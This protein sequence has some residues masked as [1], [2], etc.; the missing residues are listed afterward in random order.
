M[1]KIYIF[2]FDDT[3]WKTSAKV[4]YKNLQAN[5]EYFTLEEYTK[6]TNDHG[7]HALVLD[8]S[9][10]Y[11]LR[12]LNAGIPVEPWFSKFIKLLKQDK[13]VAIITARAR[14]NSLIKFFDE[15][16]IPINSSMVYA[17]NDVKGSYV[18]SVP[19]RKLQAFKKIIDLGYLDVEYHDDILENIKH[20]ER[21]AYE[22]NINFKYFH[23]NENS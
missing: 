16:L 22:N 6:H 14:K 11:D 19:E 3:L 9:E 23:V 1:K 12:I 8:Y 13:P 17:V 7:K 20:L 2:D 5:K 18:G 10:F 15:N 21:H 4:K